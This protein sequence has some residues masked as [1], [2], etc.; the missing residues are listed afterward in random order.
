M[1]YKNQFPLKTIYL[2]I[3]KTKRC[4]FTNEAQIKYKQY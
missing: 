1:A 2:L 4:Y 3:H